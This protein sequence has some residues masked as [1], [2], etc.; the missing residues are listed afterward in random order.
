MDL[1]AY[2]DKSVPQTDILRFLKF[3]LRPHPSDRIVGRAND[4][5]LRAGIGCLL[6]EILKINGITPV[7]IQKT[8]LDENAPVVPYGRKEGTV[9][10]RL[11]DYSVTGF[12]ECQDGAFQ[13]GYH[14]L[15]EYDLIGAADETMSA[16]VESAD[17][18]QIIL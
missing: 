5:H 18:F 11:N 4:E 16:A 1:V 8:V 7:I 17:C 13:F 15:C 2:E 10:G 12:G 6:L 3:F 14:S 9:H